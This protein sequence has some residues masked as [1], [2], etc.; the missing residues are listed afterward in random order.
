MTLSGVWKVFELISVHLRN[1]L[2]CRPKFQRPNP[3]FFILD[4]DLLDGISEASEMFEEL[5]EYSG[6][7]LFF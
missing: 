6:M 4:Q 3:L 7:A 2:F 1:L 5:R